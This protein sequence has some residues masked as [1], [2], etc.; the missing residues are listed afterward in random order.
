MTEQTAPRP[1]D[2]RS[3]SLMLLLT[4]LGAVLVLT[5]V[6]RIWAEGTVTGLDGGRLAVSATGATLTGLPGGLTLVALAAAVAVFAVRGRARTAVGVLTVLAGLG[7]A[8]GAVL[9]ATDTAGLHTEAARKLALADAQAQQIT[10]SGWPW[11]A[12]AGA[13]L[14]ALAGLL[15]VRS[16]RSWP[17]MG[18]RY[19]APVR[20]GAA[21]PR[22]A[23]SPADLW[24]ALDR[25]EDPTG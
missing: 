4:A 22:A 3:L 8:A 16:G 9:G 23:G 6:G 14:L 15:T 7:A 1:T 10:H 25:G 21:A 24:K 17:A 12:L 20:K 5:A 18:A 2:R 13:L 19:E 11:V